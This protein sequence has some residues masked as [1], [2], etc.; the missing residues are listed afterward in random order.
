LT[1]ALGER[2]TGTSIVNSPLSAARGVLLFMMSVIRGIVSH[3]NT[4]DPVDI[5]QSDVTLAP[6]G[7]LTVILPVNVRY[8]GNVSLI[9]TSVAATEPVFWYW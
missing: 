8:I 2:I 3:E 9:D 4:I 5:V 7:L 6:D 1:G